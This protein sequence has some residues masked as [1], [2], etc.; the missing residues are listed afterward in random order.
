MV[1]FL[2]KLH[3]PRKDNKEKRYNFQENTELGNNPYLNQQ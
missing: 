2:L 1:F 3:T